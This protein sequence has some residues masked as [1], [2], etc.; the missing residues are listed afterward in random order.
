MRLR[1]NLHGQLFMPLMLVA[2]FSVVL[3]QV[4]CEKKVTRKLL[5]YNSAVVEATTELQFQAIDA[6]G[7]QEIG[8]DEARG[9][10]TGTT[11][12]LRVSRE[13][14]ETLALIAEWTPDNREQVLD[15]I[16]QLAESIRQLNQDGVLRIKNDLKRAA[17]DK[18]LLVIEAALLA[19][20]EV[21]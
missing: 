20:R 13:L 10:V 4:A 12:V 7:A 17:F 1:I 2:L 6:Y 9:I 19:M 18:T 16:L 15:L 8:V 11:Q 3:S 21:L 14:N 5:R